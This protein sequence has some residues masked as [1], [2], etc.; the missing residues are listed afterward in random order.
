MSYE[1]T[2]GKVS[3]G[4][5]AS[6]RGFTDLSKAAFRYPALK[7]FFNTGVTHNVEKCRNELQKLATS[8]APDVASTALDLRGKLTGLKMAVI[9]DGVV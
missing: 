4:Q 3:L 8:S 1:V 9:T 2:D 7:R 6:N 5:V